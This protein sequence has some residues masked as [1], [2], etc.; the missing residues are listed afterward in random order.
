MPALLIFHDFAVLL[1]IIKEPGRQDACHPGHADLFILG[2]TILG[3]ITGTLSAILPSRAKMFPLTGLVMYRT[4]PS[5]M[6]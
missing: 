2:K 1:A 5:P 6:P 4:E 3:G